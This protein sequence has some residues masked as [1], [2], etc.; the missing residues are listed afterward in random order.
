VPVDQ[1]VPQEPDRVEGTKERAT[2]PMM[3]IIFLSP[4]FVIFHLP[5]RCGM[6]PRW[7]RTHGLASLSYSQGQW[8]RYIAARG[9]S[10][11]S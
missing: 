1:A 5:L 2:T 10:P 6:T 4:L 7:G 11:W 9:V 3:V 8:S